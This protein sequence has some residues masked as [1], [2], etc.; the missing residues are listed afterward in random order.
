[1]SEEQLRIDAL[2]YHEFPTPGKISIAPTKALANQRDLGLA[3][4]PGVAYACTAIQQNP[5]DAARYTAR[6]NLVAV[7]LRLQ[8]PFGI[9]GKEL[10]IIVLDCRHAG[11]RRADHVVVAGKRFD[12]LP[13][14][15][16]G[17]GKVTAVQRR[18]AA[19]GLRGRHFDAAAGIFQELHRGETYAWPKQV[20]EARREQTDARLGRGRSGFRCVCHVR[21]LSAC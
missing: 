11:A 20:H 2:E 15:I 16:A 3:Y 21:H 18:L 5:D 10:R 17:I 1:M 9:V 8:A 14:D 4:S 12:D 7:I 13:C 6:A 19:A